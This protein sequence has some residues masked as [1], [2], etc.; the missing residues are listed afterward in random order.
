M[1]LAI[2]D[3]TMLPATRHKRTHLALTWAREWYSIYLPRRDG[4]LSWPMWPVTYWDGLPAHR[5][6]PIQLLTQQCTAGSEL[7]TCWSQ[8]RRPNHYTFKPSINLIVFH[9]CV[10]VRNWIR[11]KNCTTGLH[12]IRNR[13]RF[14]CML[15][16][17]SV[18]SVG[19]KTV[20]KDTSLKWEDQM[21]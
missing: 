11:R 12:A 9:L 2:W 1:S 5:Q 19:L 4:R 17:F 8:V 14:I 15:H 16:K 3:H 20:E 7:A 6:P 13:V 18:S 10:V 21:P